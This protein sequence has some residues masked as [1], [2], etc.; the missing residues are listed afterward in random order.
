M[1]ASDSQYLTTKA[2]IDPSARTVKMAEASVTYTP[3]GEGGKVAFPLSSFSLYI[4]TK[5]RQ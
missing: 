3:E 1:F 5:W 4:K 2:F